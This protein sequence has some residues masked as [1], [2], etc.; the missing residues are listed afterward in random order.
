MRA[1]GTTLH[2][3]VAGLGLMGRRMLGSL[4]AHPGFVARAGADPDGAALARAAA[5]FG[6]EPARDLD[7]LLA[8]DD[9][10]LVY[11]ATPPA[12][13]VPVGGAVL[14]SGRPLFLEKPLAVDL[15]AAEALV[16]R[17]ERSG[18]PAALNF[19][20][21]TLPGLARLE[22]ELAEG[23]AGAPREVE[24]V[25]R[26]TQ[27]PRTWHHAGPWL[28]GAAEGGFVREVVSHFAYLTQRVLGALEVHEARVERGAAGTE[29][30]VDAR[31]TAGGVPVAL[32]GTV[33]GAARDHNLWTLRCERRAYR[34]ED[35]AELSWRAGGDWR[36]LAG[37]P[38]EARDAATQLDA[39]AALVR[40]EPSPLPSLREGLGVQRAVEALLARA[41]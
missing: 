24:L 10:D 14:A 25:V 30:S 17:A 12:S 33:G 39:L 19:P 5:E 2:V 18:L 3:G 41:D 8:R 7:A 22:R 26:F 9:L 16:A 20:F 37:D 28:A 29:V 40:G 21:A 23:T 34:L 15:A 31:L 11:V 27:W 32:T 6:L 4:A 13:H 36:P 1:H 35:W 38:G